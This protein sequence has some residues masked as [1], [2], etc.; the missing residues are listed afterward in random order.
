[1]AGLGAHAF[2]QVVTILGQL[3]LTPLYFKYW[4]AGKYGEWLMLSTIPAYL[5]MADLGIGSAAGNDMAMKVA[6][7]DRPGAKAVL[8]AILSLCKIASIGVT[9]VGVLSA[10]AVWFLPSLHPSSIPL[11]DA[12]AS[13]IILASGVGV[14]FFASTASGVYRAVG[15]NATGVLLT[16]LTRLVEVAALAAFLISN[17]GPLALCGVGFLIR[18]SSM[19][20]Q[21][22]HL[23]HSFGWL[24]GGA[25][26]REV[27]LLRRLLKPAIGFMAYPLGNALALQGPVLVIGSVMGPSASAAYAA[28]RTIARVPNQLTNVLGFSV[29]PEVSKAYGENNRDL[30]R[31]LHRTSWAATALTV[32][33]ICIVLAVAG[34]LLAEVWLHRAFDVNRYLLAGLLV[35]SA[36]SSIWNA[37]AVFLSAINAHVRLG[38]IYVAVNLAG[39]IAAIVLTRYFGWGGLMGALI[40]VELSILAWV[41][42]TVLSVT[43][44]EF[45]AFLTS[46]PNVVFRRAVNGKIFRGE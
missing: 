26:A 17:C 4:G 14:G 40:L 33:A 46:I 16:N 39:L 12:I 37:S 35:V 5:V 1:M 42:R 43:G 6:V 21:W 9:V 13:I 44:D 24:V 23:R 7:G 15:R 31:K 25:E 29:W 22:Q 8:S 28:L 38:A 34:P 11:E 10:A 27:G 45:S 20:L 36:L 41:L 2:G 32:F 19:A 18:L 30:L 3:A